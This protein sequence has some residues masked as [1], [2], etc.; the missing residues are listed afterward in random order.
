MEGLV[1]ARYQI[2]RKLG[3]GGMGVVY[4]ADDTRLPR[5]VAIKVLHEDATGDDRARFKREARAA[6]A[7][8]HPN[9]V[10][11]HDIES[12]TERDFI[13]MELVEGESL[14]AI[15]AR[16]PLP[17]AKAIEYALA[18]ASAFGAAHAAGIVHRDIKPGNVMITADGRVKVLDFGLAKMIVRAE[19]SAETVTAAHQT[20]QGTLLGTLAYM[21]PEQAVGEP[22]DARSDVFS[23]GVVL[24]EMLTGRRPFDG[25]S[26]AATVRAILNDPPPSVSRLRRDV[27]ASVQRLVE[28]CLQKDP[29]ARYAH[30]GDIAGELAA[31]QALPVPPVKYRAYVAIGIVVALLAGGV[32]WTRRAK[33]RERTGT[34]AAINGHVDA[35]YLAQALHLAQALERRFPDD[36]EIT[37]T[38]DAFT[39]RS[40]VVSAPEGAD[41][42]VRDYVNPDSDWIPFGTTPITNARVP[43]AALKVIFTCI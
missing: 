24:Y 21:S 27:P 5:K 32:E 16:G 26:T 3:E 29:R 4:E 28:R 6:S 34:L 38:L 1:L 18:M 25:G 31:L 43:F 2:R 20:H 40:N 22:A 36:A 10:T 8:N 17:L 9:I 14:A 41:V 7:L 42:L 30:A 39:M 33:Q 35:G 11:V 13:V 19:P 15:L 12:T 23:F 37:R